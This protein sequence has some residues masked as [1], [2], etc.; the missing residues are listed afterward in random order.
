MNQQT[1][2][3]LHLIDAGDLGQLEYDWEPP[4]SVL[5]IH[6]GGGQSASFPLSDVP[7]LIAAL[8][9]LQR[10]MD[11]AGWPHMPLPGLEATV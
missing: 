5:H 7:A 1:S 2:E 6:D 8:T 10:R 3:S 4:W 11:A 9:E